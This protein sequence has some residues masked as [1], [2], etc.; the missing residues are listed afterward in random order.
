MKSP[1]YTV[2]RLVHPDV[3]EKDKD[4]MAHFIFHAGDC[5]L[6]KKSLQQFRNVWNGLAELRQDRRLQQSL[7]LLARRLRFSNMICERLLALFGKAVGGDMQ[8]SSV[9]KVCSCGQL[10]QVRCEHASLE[11]SNPCVITRNQFLAEGVQIKAKSNSA[12]Q[13]EN[14]QPGLWPVYW[15]RRLQERKARCSEE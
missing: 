9:E 12:A 5:C 1:P 14:R 2:M 8:H 7:R 6:P 11:R 15:R 10:A 13:Q 3:S 4:N